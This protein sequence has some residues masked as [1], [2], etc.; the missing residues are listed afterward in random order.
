MRWNITYV[1]K[2]DRPNEI[3][4]SVRAALMARGWRP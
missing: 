1:I 4:R 2:E 3:V